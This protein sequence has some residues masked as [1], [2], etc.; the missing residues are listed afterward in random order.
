LFFKDAKLFALDPLAGKFMRE[1]P[2]CDLSKAA[3]VYSR[4]AEER[5]DAL[6][7]RMDLIICMNVLDHCFDTGKVLEN[8]DGY[9]VEGGTL[10]LSVDVD[11][12]LHHLHPNLVNREYLIGWFERMGYAYTIL[13]AS[14]SPYGMGKKFTVRATK[15]GEVR[16]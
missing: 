10:L 5:V 4:P 2:W 15:S 16:Q 7:G 6:T 3:G 1:V 8:L 12:G 11:H 9:L 13:D 14:A